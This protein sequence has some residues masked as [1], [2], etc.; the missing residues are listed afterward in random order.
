MRHGPAQ[1][2]DPNKSIPSWVTSRGG[3]NQMR[4]ASLRSRCRTPKVKSGRVGGHDGGKCDMSYSTAISPQMKLTV[5]PCSGPTF[6]VVGRKFTQA[7]S[8]ELREAVADGPILFRGPRTF[9][10]KFSGG[11][12][13]FSPSSSAV[14]RNNDFSVRRCGLFE[15]GDLTLHDIFDIRADDIAGRAL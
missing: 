7:A 9:T 3:G 4:V 8:S 6:R 12:R 5:P 13:G 14:R 11:C 10:T 2:F 15:H 1:A